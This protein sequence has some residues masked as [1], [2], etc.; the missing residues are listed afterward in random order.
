MKRSILLTVYLAILTAFSGLA[1][2]DSAMVTHGGDV[3][4]SDS[5]STLDIDTPRDAFITGF[6]VEVDGSIAHDAHV[7]GFDVEIE[8]RVGGNLYA[9]GSNLSLRAPVQEDATIAGFNV[10]LEEAAAVG[11]NVRLAGGAVEIEAPVGGSLMATGGVITLDASI[12]GDARLSG[13]E[14]K[15]GP[16]ASI[17]GTLTYSAPEELDIPA[18]VAPSERVRYVPYTHHGRYGDIGK[19]IDDAM[20]GIWP[21]ALGGFVT[22]V[23]VLAF[24]LLVAALFLAFA[25]D[26]VEHLHQRAVK[27]TGLSILTGFLGLATLFG[28]VPVSAMTLVGIPLI[29]FVLLFIIALWTLAFLLGSYVI[30]LRLNG[31]FRQSPETNGGRLLVLAAGLIGLTLINFIP[32][33]GWLFNLAVMFLGLGS[34]TLSF[35]NKLAQ[36]NATETAEVTT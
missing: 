7:A 30:A 26:R 27:H 6:S 12:K 18:S 11:G 17:G 23:V 35:I 21:S 1:L 5:S 19:T 36:K 8:G 34:I 10:E 24:L 29:P 9:V 15:F 2:A 33:I 32:F 4:V 3:F 31:S 22:V 20:P 28:L 25:G 14:L 13:G 16:K